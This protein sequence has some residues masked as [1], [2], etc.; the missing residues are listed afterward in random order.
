M[1]I[2][3]V[4]GSDSGKQLAIATE[5]HFV[6]CECDSCDDFWAQFDIA[7]QEYSCYENRKN[8]SKKCRLT[9]HIMDGSTN[10]DGM[11]T[12]EDIVEKV[13]KLQRTDTSIVDPTDY[14]RHEDSGR[15]TARINA[16]R[17]N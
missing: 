15:S 17:R 11:E 10:S 3:K 7:W 13:S 14:P 6:E 1:P 16:T 12:E 2:K 9:S 8:R 4:F 5:Q